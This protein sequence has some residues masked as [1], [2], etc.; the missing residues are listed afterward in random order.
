MI[1]RKATAADTGALRA[2]MAAS[3]GYQRPA[4]R[5]MIKAY[6]AGWSVPEGEHEVWVAENDGG[7]LA[8]F[9]QL[10]PDGRQ[11]ELDLFFTSNASQ[12]GGVGRTLFDH[13]RKRAR[14]L[15]AKVVAISSNPEA[16]GF[17]RRMGA[18]DAGVTPPGQGIS[19]E[20]PRLVLPTRIR[21]ATEADARAVAELHRLATRTAMPFLPDLHTP[22]EDLAF[23]GEE[24]ARKETWVS[25]ADDGGV[26]GFLV[27]RPGWVEHLAVHPAEQGK[28]VGSGLMQ[29]AKARA[30]DLQLWTFQ[31]NTAARAFYEKRGFHLVRLTDGSR[32]EEKEPDCL[33]AWSEAAEKAA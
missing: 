22:A 19:W 11:Q 24:I 27:L 5:K 4:A 21:R 28:G 7:A 26:R 2:M 1:L 6:A 25:T 17:Y 20:R 18:V 30:N 8:G 13:M 32:N 33:Y 29:L 9:Y 3:N 10:I 14:E 23:F 31:R 12:G 16:A 15:G